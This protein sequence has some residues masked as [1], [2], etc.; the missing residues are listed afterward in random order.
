MCVRLGIVLSCFSV[1]FLKQLTDWESLYLGT[2][3]SAIL[4][5]KVL[6]SSTAGAQ[7]TSR[8]QQSSWH[9]WRGRHGHL[10]KAGG[11]LTHKQ[12]TPH[13]NVGGKFIPKHRFAAGWNNPGF[14]LALFR[15]TPRQWHLS[16][17]ENTNTRTHT[18]THT[19]S[20]CELVCSGLFYLVKLSST[21]T[22]AR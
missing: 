18:L 19:H 14:S 9:T 1:P 10:M 5:E 13:R 4:N 20:R 21:M 12:S 2:A 16:N 3:F 11:T 7:S 22:S 8:S 6:G 17:I 15:S